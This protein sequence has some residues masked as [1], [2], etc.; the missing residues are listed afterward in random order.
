MPIASWRSADIGQAGRRGGTFQ[1]VQHVAH[2]VGLRAA[3]RAQL[4]LA[5]RAA[6]DVGDRGQD[7]GRRHVERGHVGGVGVDGV[8][9]G[10]RAR[11]AVGV[12]AG[13]HQAG[14]LQP[15]EQLAGG[16]LGE[17]GQVAESA[18]ATVAR[19]R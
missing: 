1:R 5:D 17:P 3:R 14:A 4:V 12:P 11:P 15:A 2:G 7:P 18:T 6:G 13:D 8:Q 19:A 10:A 16:G 9:L